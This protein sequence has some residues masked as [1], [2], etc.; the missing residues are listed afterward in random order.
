MICQMK[1]KFVIC[2]CATIQKELE[3]SVCEDSLLGPDNLTMAILSYLEDLLF[4]SFELD[5]K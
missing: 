4:K 3:F 5:V 2:C 1:V